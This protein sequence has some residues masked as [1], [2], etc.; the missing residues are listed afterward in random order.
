MGAPEQ[1]LAFISLG[2]FI[3]AIIYMLLKELISFQ[4]VN[5]T[6]L[7]NAVIKSYDCVRLSELVSS[8]AT[9]YILP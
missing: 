9:V 4:L 8:G 3:N 6:N 2:I 5:A 1:Y 7:K